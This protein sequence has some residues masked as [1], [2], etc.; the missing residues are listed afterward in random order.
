VSDASKPSAD[1]P[2][3]QLSADETKLSADDSARELSADELSA[4]ESAC[5]LS[6]DE[7]TRLREAF[8]RVP[9]ARLLGL[10]FVGAARGEATFALEV[11]EELTRMGGIAHGG[12]L[13]SLLDTAA[14]FAV[15][16][17]LAPEE[18][19]VTVDLTVH[20]LRPAGEG[21]VEARARV[22][23]AGRRIVIITAEA[24]DR[25][26]LLVATATTTYVRQG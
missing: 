14:A 3:R 20:F 7:T 10:E 26:G 13:A 6:A 5:E 25:A 19:T 16:T 8:A 1:K 23:R 21:R 11:R 12:A 15:H 2:A 24:T 4:D 18:R 9:Y 22:L 17:L